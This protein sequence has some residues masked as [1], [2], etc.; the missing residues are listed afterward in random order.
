MAL[1]L[2]GNTAMGAHFRS[3]LCHFICSSHDTRWSKLK[4][5]FRKK[6]I[7]LYACATC[8][9]ELPFNISAMVLL[10]TNLLKTRRRHLADESDILQNIEKHKGRSKKVHYTCWNH[11]LSQRY[12]YLW[13]EYNLY[14]PMKP[15]LKHLVTNLWMSYV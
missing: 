5:F 10:N 12:S 2:V 3:N 15:M 1:E 14:H 11:S 6:S 7:F 4:C 13:T 9:S 8:S